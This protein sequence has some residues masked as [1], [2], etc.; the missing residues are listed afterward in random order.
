[1]LFGTEPA[2]RAS[3]SPTAPLAPPADDDPLKPLAAVGAPPPPE[4]AVVMTP[5]Q[6][7]AQQRAA[8]ARFRAE[9]QSA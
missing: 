2:T 8:H 3:H 9:Q 7:W 5:E 1:M 4:N 6:F